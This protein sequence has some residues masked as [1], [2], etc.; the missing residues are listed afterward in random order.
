MAG[1]PFAP[2]LM[3]TSQRRWRC[4]E[5]ASQEEKDANEEENDACQCSAPSWVAEWSEEGGL[6]EMFRDTGEIFC[7]SSSAARDGS[8]G[9]GIVSGLYERGVLVFEG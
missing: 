5:D 1:H 9:V 2:A 7:S 8:R 3:H 6:R 4:D